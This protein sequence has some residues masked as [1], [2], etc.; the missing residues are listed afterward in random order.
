MCNTVYLYTY[1]YI[2]N[3]FLQGILHHRH[4][5]WLNLINTLQVGYIRV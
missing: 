5:Q 4:T 3:F 2:Y 1:I